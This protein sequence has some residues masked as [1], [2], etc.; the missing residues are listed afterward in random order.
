M[1]LGR[2]LC[3]SRCDVS[4][5]QRTC[6]AEHSWDP[7]A[8]GQGGTGGEAEETRE[9]ATETEACQRAPLRDVNSQDTALTP[10]SSLFHRP[11][12]RRAL[13]LPAD[14]SKSRLTASESVDAASG[15]DEGNRLGPNHQYGSIQA[16]TAHQQRGRESSHLS[17]ISSQNSITSLTLSF[18]SFSCS[19][20]PVCVLGGAS[21]GT[22]AYTRD[23]SGGRE[24][25]D[26]V[27]WREVVLSMDV[28][29]SGRDMASEESEDPGRSGTFRERE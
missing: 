23:S 13:S 7:V 8:I 14:C 19:A 22:R 27:R 26:D 1:R 16:P 2:L 29:L 24:G 9:C 5:L 11:P 21:D 28:R 3:E 12:N 20:S 15:V 25:W 17:M 18:L 10:R 6:A 4:M